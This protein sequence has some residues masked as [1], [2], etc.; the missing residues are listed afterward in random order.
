MSKEEMRQESKDNDGN[1]QIK[2]RIRRLQKQMRRQLMLKETEK[3]TVVV[4]NPTHFAVAL[5]YSMDMG[6]PGRNRQRPKFAGAKDE[7]DCALERD[8]GDGES[9]TGA[10]AIQN[11]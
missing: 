3:A 6:A 1:P 4:T 7:R 2:M 10:G 8:S 11:G 5:M 9:A